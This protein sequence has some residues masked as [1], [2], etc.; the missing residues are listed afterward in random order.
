[1]AP[2]STRPT[3]PAGNWALDYSPSQVNLLVSPGNPAPVTWLDFT[4]AARDEAVDLK[5]TTGS[6]ENSDYFGVERQ[7]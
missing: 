2:F 5:W 7:E 1:M 3:L 6:E 4:A